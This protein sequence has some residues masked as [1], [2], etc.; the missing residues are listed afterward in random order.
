VRKADGVGAIEM[1]IL[2]AYKVRS[3]GE[4]CSLA[5]LNNPPTGW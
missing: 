3:S 5:W 2:Q 1:S 4:G